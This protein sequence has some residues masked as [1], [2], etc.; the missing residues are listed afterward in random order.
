MN[1]HVDYVA[2]R[3][4]LFSCPN[5]YRSVKSLDRRIP[6][7][8]HDRPTTEAT[9][10]SGMPFSQSSI[11]ARS[12]KKSMY[13]CM[14]RTVKSSFLLPFVGGFVAKMFLLSFYFL[15]QR[16]FTTLSPRFYETKKKKTVLWISPT[17]IYLDTVLLFALLQKAAAAARLSNTSKMD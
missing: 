1:E 10:P 6:E 12:V 9:T 17:F 4:L 13:V 8:A 5:F 14:N 16:I 15:L 7:R 2:V 11:N 3:L